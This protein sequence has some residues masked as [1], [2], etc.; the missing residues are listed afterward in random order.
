M[1][2]ALKKCIIFFISNPFCIFLIPIAFVFALLARFKKW[3]VEKPRLVWGSTPIISYSYFSRSMEEHG[4][5]SQTFTDSYYSTINDRDDWDKILK[6]EYQYFPQKT[7]PIVAFIHSLL[8]YDIF[9]LSFDGYFLGNTLM[10]HLQAPL[11]KLAGKKI[12]VIPYGSDAYV[13]RRI[14]STSWISALMI[15]YPGASKNQHRIAKNVDY[16][17]KYAD[18]VVATG[19][20]VDGIGRWDVLLLNSSILDLKKWQKTNKKYNS[21][22]T[23]EQVVVAHTPNHRGCKGTEFVIEAVNKLQKE[24]LKVK[25]LL[26]EKIKNSE[27][28]KSLQSEVD[29]LVEQLIFTGHG[30]SGLEGMASGLPTISNLEDEDYTLPMRR[31]SYLD[32]CPLVSA[33]PENIVDVLRKLITNPQLRDELGKAGRKYVEK[34]HGYDSA[35]YLFSNVIDYI[36]GKKESIINLYHPILGEYPNRT[37]KIEHPLVNNRIED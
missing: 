15:S 26:F 8:K 36:Y 20:G 4:Y 12:V 9:F 37:P 17:N 22:G 33:T 19:M 10:R 28:Q 3:S 29:I 16:W 30:L 27:V 7:K 25:L 31:W 11:L 34:Y 1:L 2:S 14:R 35:H 18:A 6:E 23:S 13:Y 24:G 21:N 32:E 5:C